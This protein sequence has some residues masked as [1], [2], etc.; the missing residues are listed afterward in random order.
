MYGLF[1][2]CALKPWCF[3]D[4]AHTKI[5]QPGNPSLIQSIN[6]FQC[7][8]AVA[9]DPGF[10]FTLAFVTAQLL[11]R[12]RLRPITDQLREYLDV[13]ET[14][15]NPLSGERVYAMRRVSNQQHPAF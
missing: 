10:T 14:E 15:I 5:T 2:Q 12:D 9:G 8:V 6:P 7:A 4:C 11:L 3:I 1:Q 13:T